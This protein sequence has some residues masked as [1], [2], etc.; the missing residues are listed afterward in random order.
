MKHRKPESRDRH[1]GLKLSGFL[2]LSY[3]QLL[4]SFYEFWIHLVSEKINRNMISTKNYY[5]KL[6]CFSTNI[7][8]LCYI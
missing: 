5:Q 1:L 7:P 2:F 4:V 6:M 8:I 3:D